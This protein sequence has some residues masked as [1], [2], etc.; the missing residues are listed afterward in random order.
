MIITKRALF[1]LDYDSSDKVIQ[2]YR[3]EVDL[4]ELEIKMDN[5]MRPPYYEVFK[6]FK[7]GKR[8]VNERLFGSSHMDKIISFINSYLG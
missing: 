3:T 4:M 6:W 5:T 8:K 7:D 2:H 1:V